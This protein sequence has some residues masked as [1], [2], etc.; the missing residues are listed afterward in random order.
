MYVKKYTKVKQKTG[1]IVFPC[2][3]SL[4][5]TVLLILTR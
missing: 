4:L 2:F 1:A 5:I 3:L